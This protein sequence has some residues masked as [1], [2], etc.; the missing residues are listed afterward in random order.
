MLELAR[1]HNA[2]V[3][4]DDWA[5]D[6]ALESE[7]APPPMAREDR[8]GHVLYL[9]SLSKCAAPG[10]RIAALCARGPA[11][12]RLRTARLVDDFFVPGLMQEMA[13]QL[14][15]AAAWPRHLR[16]LRLALRRN[17]D[18]LSEAL[19]RHLGSAVPPPILPAGGLHLWLRLPEGRSDAD[20]VAA[21]AANGVLVTPGRHAFPAEPPGGFLRLS[22]A[23]LEP[24]WVEDAAQVIAA[25]AVG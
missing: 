18:L 4:E 13:L 25:A 22:F 11:A 23:T 17:R 14:V 15:T 1:R 10:L 8:D 12:E 6:F 21:A 7:G 5:H 20:A 24:D 2:F 3:L 19:A 16:Q 9:R